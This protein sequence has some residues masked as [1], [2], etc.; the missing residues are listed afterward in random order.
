MLAVSASW[1]ET[2]LPPARLEKRTVGVEVAHELGRKLA[3]GI[4]LRFL[5]K[6]LAFDQEPFVSSPR[7]S[8]RSGD[9][10]ERLASGVVL[11]A[12]RIPAQQPLVAA[13]RRPALLI[14][15]H[16]LAPLLLFVRLLLLGERCLV[17]TRIG[18]IRDHRPTRS[19]LHVRI[20]VAGGVRRAKR[21]I[22]PRGRA[23]PA[24][25]SGR[26]PAD[27]AS[28]S[29]GEYTQNAQARPLRAPAFS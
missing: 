12:I 21:A 26:S 10:V 15:H 29:Q 22:R 19:S 6:T 8:R 16:V 11:L 4:E 1:F 24:I 14:R 18:G 23:L 2:R 5:E 9:P 27:H 17:A 25:G 3:V 20:L 13:L 7:V 28:P